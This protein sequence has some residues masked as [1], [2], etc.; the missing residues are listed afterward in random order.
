[1]R[2]AAVTHSRAICRVVACQGGGRIALEDR[3][4]PAPGPSEMLLHLNV[5]GLCGTDLFKLVN[6]MVPA[7]TVLGH[8][9]VGTV[10]ALGS[11]VKGFREGDRIV[12]P[13]H[14]PCGACILCRRGNETMCA[15]FKE[16]LMEPGGFADAILIRKRAV[17]LAALS[18]P[19]ALP[20]E[21]AVFV[22]PAACVLRG[23]E[24]SGIAGE[25]VAVV[26]GAGSM[27]LLHLLVLRA[28]RPDVAVIVIDPEPERR[29][30]AERLG[31][32]SAAAPG[33]DACAALGAAGHNLGADVVFDTVGG[34]EALSAAVTLTRPGGSVVL[35]AHA[36]HGAGAALDLNELF[37]SERRVVATYSGSL[38]E[39]K[40]VFDLLCD[41]RLDPSPLVTHRM[42]LDDFDHGV[43]LVRRRQ[44]LKVLFTPS[45]AAAS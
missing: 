38:R 35:F 13:H 29:R 41:G 17:A 32:V 31:A 25:G 23:I 39:Q 43:E 9:I 19:D 24:R 27:G 42:P 33:G 1:M 40:A 30:L 20:D 12:V 4:F 45:R 3:L 22:E 8:E 16:N 34:S 21:A 36:P 37:K 10:L 2:I 14:V 11:G 26:L 18:V 6:D 15:A 44:A 28:T 7:G 5:A